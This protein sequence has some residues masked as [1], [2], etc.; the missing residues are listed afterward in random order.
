VAGHKSGRSISA[1]QAGTNRGANF[2]Y[3]HAPKPP[4][5]QTTVQWL[6]AILFFFFLEFSLQI[7]D[8]SVKYT[9]QSNST[10]STK[11]TDPTALR[12]RWYMT[13]S[14]IGTRDSECGAGTEQAGPL[15]A[16]RHTD[17]TKFP[18]LAGKVTG[19]ALEHGVPHE[20]PGEDH[21]KLV[22]R[23]GP[24]GE[25]LK[26]HHHFLKIQFLQLVRPLRWVG[27]AEE[28]FQSIRNFEFW[29]A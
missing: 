9:N 27:E 25:V 5:C 6:A 3:V 24:C 14:K 22:V 16:H 28:G 18:L 29:Q 8:S 1:Y 12:P 21:L 17:P 13:N 11:K 2:E 26:E 10:C 23:P 15:A 7:F 4:K 20:S 19:R